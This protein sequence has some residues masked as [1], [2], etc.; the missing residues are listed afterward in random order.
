MC[1]VNKHTCVHVHASNRER[2]R[3][4]ERQTDRQT[5]RQTGRQ[6]G[7]QAGRQTDRQTD[8]QRDIER[9][10]EGE[11]GRECERGREDIIRKKSPYNTYIST[12]IRERM[13]VAPH[14][15]L[16]STSGLCNLDHNTIPYHTILWDNRSIR[17]LFKQP[18]EQT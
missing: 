10:K 1:F 11:R 9:E 4:E 13:Q 12:S 16:R 5:D 7:R 6:A 18:K 15:S 3:A 17:A 2:D 8:S 14:G